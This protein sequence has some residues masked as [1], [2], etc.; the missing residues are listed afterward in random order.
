MCCDFAIANKYNKEVAN[1]VV[2]HS[3]INIIIYPSI[4][5]ADRVDQAILG[6]V[7]GE[8]LPLHTAIQANFGQ[9][10]I[11][12]S[13]QWLILKLNGHITIALIS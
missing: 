12:N 6:A 1:I 7:S 11:I 2:I 4:L 13:T 10:Y 5:R 3:F 8:Y 9:I